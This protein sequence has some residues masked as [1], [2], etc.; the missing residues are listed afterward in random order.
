MPIEIKELHIKA[1]VVA[2]QQSLMSRESINVAK[3]KREISEEVLRKLMQKLGQKN[4]R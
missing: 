4:E 3:L 1:V 2:D